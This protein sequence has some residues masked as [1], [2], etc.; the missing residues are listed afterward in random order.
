[1][2]KGPQV[3]WLSRQQVTWYVSACTLESTSMCSNLGSITPLYPLS[4]TF[5]IFKSVN[6]QHHHE[7]RT[8]KESF[9]HSLSSQ[10]KST[11]VL[12][13]FPGPHGPRSQERGQVP[14]SGCLMSFSFHY[15]T[16][17]MDIFLLR[18]FSGLWL[19]S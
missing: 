17:H 15:T 10:L 3:V 1:M 18:R 14:I 6:S 13:L 5:P 19:H 4:L 9:K 12:L 2:Y 7:M 16:L 11:A 8:S